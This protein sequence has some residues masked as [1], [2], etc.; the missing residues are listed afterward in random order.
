MA[1]ES[2]GLCTSCRLFNRY[3]EV[4]QDICVVRTVHDDRSKISESSSRER[5]RE[6]MPSFLVVPSAI[7]HSLASASFLLL[8]GGWLGNQAK[9]GWFSQSQS[10]AHKLCIAA[11]SK[12][13]VPS[14]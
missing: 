6:Q 10:K 2:A 3:L 9:T 11:R 7:P 5:E 1:G 4:K 14:R 13:L 12:H 8:D